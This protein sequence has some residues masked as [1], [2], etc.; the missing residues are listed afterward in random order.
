MQS[1]T[2]QQVSVLASQLN[3]SQQRRPPPWHAVATALHGPARP[4]TTRNVGKSEHAETTTTARVSIAPASA[5]GCV[6]VAFWKANMGSVGDG[7]IRRKD[8]CRER[9]RFMPLF[10][11]WQAHLSQQSSRHRHIRPG[12]EVVCTGLHALCD[13]CARLCARVHTMPRTRRRSARSTAPRARTRGSLDPSLRGRRRP[14]R[15]TCGSALSSSR[16]IAHL[17]VH[18]PPNAS[19]SDHSRGCTPLRTPHPQT[20]A[21]VHTPPNVSPSDRSRGGHPPK[22][23]PSD[24]SGGAHPSEGSRWRRDE[25]KEEIDTRITIARNAPRAPAERAA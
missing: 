17:G 1:V 9:K 23:S 19:P 18:T 25:A 24:R 3:S 22:A 7:C 12:R 20:E 4:E 14:R 16:A 10:S 21:G 2:E 15:T 11:S 6:R 5:R 8:A 13:E